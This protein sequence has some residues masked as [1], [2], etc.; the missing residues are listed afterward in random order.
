MWWKEINF[1]AT[2]FVLFDYVEE[3]D[4]LFIYFSEKNS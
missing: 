1:C 2:Y 4:V 3:R